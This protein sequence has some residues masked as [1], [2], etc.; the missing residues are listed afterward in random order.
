MYVG[1][2]IECLLEEQGFKLVDSDGVQTAFELGDLR[3]TLDP[4]ECDIHKIYCEFSYNGIV[5][6]DYFYDEESFEISLNEVIGKV[7]G[8]LFTNLNVA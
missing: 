8:N 3:V 6:G 4:R 7:M 1:V 2:L 5:S